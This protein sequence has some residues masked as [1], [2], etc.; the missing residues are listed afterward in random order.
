MNNK[1]YASLLAILLVA[2]SIAVAEEQPRP[3]T[4]RPAPATKITME[5]ATKIA[6]ERVPGEVT[7]V[8]IERKKGRSVY[9]I[10]IQTKDGEKDVFVDVASGE[11]VGIE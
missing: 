7:E 2:P 5:Q 1:I 8:K 3:G 6:L 4:E 9:A 11:I 10:E